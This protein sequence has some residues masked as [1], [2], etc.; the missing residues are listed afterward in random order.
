MDCP[1]PLSSE[2]EDDDFGD[3][4]DQSALPNRLNVDLFDNL[5]RSIPADDDRL[6]PPELPPSLNVSPMSPHSFPVSPKSPDSPDFFGFNADFSKVEPTSYED[7][8]IYDTKETASNGFSFAD[9]DKEE[10]YKD[11][12]TSTV[13]K[14]DAEFGDFDVSIGESV[15]NKDSDLSDL[16]DFNDNNR[17][18]S[19]RDDFADD[20]S[21]DSDFG[22]FSDFGKLDDSDLNE[23]IEQDDT[24]PGLR[25]D[26]NDSNEN[27][28]SID[29]SQ[30]P[31]EFLN[32]DII[33]PIL[34]PSISEES[35]E[36]GFSTES[37][38]CKIEP[39][40]E[41]ET[42]ELQVVEELEGTKELAK[43]SSEYD[44]SDLFKNFGRDFS[45]E[46]ETPSPLAG[47]HDQN[48]V[49]SWDS[50]EE[51]AESDKCPFAPTAPEAE[52]GRPR[53]ALFSNES[54]EFGETKVNESTLDLDTKETA[55]DKEQTE[56]SREFSAEGATTKAEIIDK[57]ED[58]LGFVNFNEN[59]EVDFADFS[60][61]SELASSTS[62]PNIEDDVLPCDVKDQ[63]CNYDTVQA[64]TISNDFP[65]FN[66]VQADKDFDDFGDFG[67]Q[68]KGDSVHAD[69]GQTDIPNKDVASDF[70]DFADF[71]TAKKSDGDAMFGDFDESTA[72][73]VQAGDFNDNS[74]ILDNF[75]SF[76]D[77][78]NKDS[79]FD[80]FDD[81]A[82]FETD[83]KDKAEFDDFAEFG[84]SP[85]LTPNRDMTP[86]TV[87]P[88]CY[89]KRTDDA[90]DIETSSYTSGRWV[91]FVIS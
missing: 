45:F 74:K 67:D 5:S 62:D 7:K 28:E 60:S 51:T 57:L 73:K 52:C 13:K 54:E 12:F 14:G 10:S 19:D 18:E 30:S 44:K 40:T 72:K 87:I 31:A 34:E 22:D 80:E 26:P 69:V 58:E 84:S 48:P 11:G 91:N 71:D 36:L 32:D 82:D 21:E 2:D 53:F 85:K 66:E 76:K 90:E 15:D 65:A 49:F 1:P 4:T 8:I 55:D 41:P 29:K 16:G 68:S 38:K 33:E 46:I 23:V 3:F 17:I 81:F 50:L 27:P 75:A 83:N 37:Y 43:P 79:D 77:D 63:N 59:S 88:K 47:D 56:I 78:E 89:K 39:S 20:K 25:Y 61:E 6:E 64:D 86:N 42:T 35:R 24:K 9:F 70:D